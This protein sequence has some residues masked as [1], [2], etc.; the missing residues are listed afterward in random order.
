MTDQ[1]PWDAL[2]NTLHSATREAARKLCCPD[3]G[4]QLRLGFQKVENRSAILISC[5][6]CKSRFNACGSFP[7][8]P[9][10]MD[11]GWIYT[12]TGDREGWAVKF[13]QPQ[14]PPVPGETE[15]NDYHR[16]V[17]LVRSYMKRITFPPVS[18]QGS[19]KLP[20][21]SE[22]FVEFYQAPD[23]SC[24]RMANSKAGGLSLRKVTSIGPTS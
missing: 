3:C 6:V 13:D 21:T 4:G 2:G 12:E 14:L 23:G 24:W 20:N 9:W 19:E 11:S 17:W 1:S 7:K 8:P 5:V 16:V 22:V 15:I 10:A 18:I